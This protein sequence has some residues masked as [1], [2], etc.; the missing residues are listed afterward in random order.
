MYGYYVYNENLDSDLIA[1][2]YPD[3]SAGNLYHCVR[4]DSG[5]Y[6]ADLSYQGTTNTV[7]SQVYFKETN[8]E[9]NDYSDLIHLT[10]VMN[11]TPDATYLQQINTVMDVDNWLTF[12]AVQ[13]YIAN[14]ETTISSGVGDDYALYR[15]VVDPRFRLQGYDLDTIVGSGGY[16]GIGDG[17]DLSDGGD[18][19]VEP[20][21]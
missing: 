19:G 8:S 20:V 15:G 12:F 3:D 17:L 4:L 11:N 14:N 6:T 5:A 21:Y 10:D 16:P 13:A 1:K 7:Y 2:L 18:S 9:E